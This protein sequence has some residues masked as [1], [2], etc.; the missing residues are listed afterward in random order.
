MSRFDWG[1]GLSEV[2]SN[3]W[4][5]FMTAHHSACFSSGMS[6]NGSPAKPESPVSKTGA[7]PFLL[8]ATMVPASLVPVR[9]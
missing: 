4:I 2:K 5:C 6:L 3:P 1:Y 9:Y 7:S 8:I